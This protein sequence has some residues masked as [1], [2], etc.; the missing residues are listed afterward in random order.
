MI[1]NVKCIKCR[2]FNLIFLLINKSISRY[3]LS[4]FK[5]E[6]FCVLAINK[7]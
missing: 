5:L 2:Q 1:T 7:C 4:N 6:I 3:L